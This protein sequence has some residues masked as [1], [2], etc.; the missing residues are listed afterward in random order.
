MRAS[1]LGSLVALLSLASFAGC[2]RSASP[3]YVPAAGSS[4]SF[5]IRTAAQKAAGL[6]YS[7]A[8]G[9]N[10]VSY[11]LKGTG[12]NNPLAGTLSGPFAQPQGMGVDQNGDLYVSNG[13]DEDILVFAAGSTSP[14]G[15]L[16]D[17]N[18][19][20]D[21]VAIAR[22]GTVYVA[23]GSGPIGA[24]GNV[25]VYAPGATSPTSTLNDKN[26]LHVVGVALDKNGNLFVSCNAQQAIGTGTVVEFKVGSSTP[27]DTHIK[28]GYAGGIAIDGSGHIAV[29][30]QE[31]PSLNIYDVGN[32]KPIATPNLPSASAYIAFNRTSKVLF[33]ADYSKGEID[34]FDYSPS[35]LKRINRITN[36]ITPSNDNMGIAVTP[37]QRL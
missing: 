34:V 25:V 37:A 28:L 5:A 35:A 12:P 14:T 30:D 32:Q 20:P 27:I 16:D 29:V 17:L 33:V 10:T 13:N 11:Y 21:D 15:T 24:S 4:E 6:I 7:S 22:D 26:F 9:G 1:F 23:N 3:S 36:G 2:S 8:F 19:F 18:K 31:V